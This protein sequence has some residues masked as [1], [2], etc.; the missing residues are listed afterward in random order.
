MSLLEKM[1]KYLRW[2]DNRIWHIVSGLSEEE[3][4]K[5]LGKNIGSLKKRYVHLAE[6]YL[7]WY[8]Y[9]TGNDSEELP[10][11]DSMDRNELFKSIQQS[12]NKFIAMI[13][14][15]SINTIQMDGEK[16]VTISFEE[17]FFH[18]VNHA[19]YHRG[20]IVMALRML[21]KDVQMT[22]YVPYRVQTAS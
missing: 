12:I 16:K 17:I 19:T 5:D 4:S 14:N 22:D 20:Q 2:A 18:L 15:P 7:D 21:D 9:W 3:Y 6:D 10:D 13:K 1:A 11:F 8:N